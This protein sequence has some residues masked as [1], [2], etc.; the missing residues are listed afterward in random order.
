MMRIIRWHTFLESGLKHTTVP[1]IRLTAQGND[2]DPSLMSCISLLQ[3]ALNR[4]A[5]TNARKI[6][7]VRGPLCHFILP[8]FHVGD[9]FE[10]GSYSQLYLFHTPH[11]S[12]RHPLYHVL[13]PQDVGTRCYYSDSAKMKLLLI[14]CRSFPATSPPDNTSTMLPS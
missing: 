3:A 5:T 6:L 12:T 14:H 7:Q 10:C 13:I 1:Q 4:L 9:I 8:F 11:G 2:P